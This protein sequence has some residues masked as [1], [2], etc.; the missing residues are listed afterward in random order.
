M[1]TP[2]QF[3]VFLRLLPP[4]LSPRARERNRNK[5]YHK[6]LT[7]LCWF[8]CTSCLTLSSISWISG[9]S[10]L[11]RMIKRNFTFQ[12]RLFSFFLLSIHS[13]RLTFFFRSSNTVDEINDT[14]TTRITQ[15]PAERDVFPPKRLD[16]LVEEKET[17]EIKFH[18]P[19]FC[20][21]SA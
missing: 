12:W 17:F 20:E 1:A 18:P 14:L 13:A 9:F 5:N 8:L 6:F 7:V 21:P 15:K 16:W 3:Q 2:H 11:A 4:F 19:S 10:R